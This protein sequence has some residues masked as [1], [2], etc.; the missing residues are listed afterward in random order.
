MSGEYGDSF[1][2]EMPSGKTPLEYAEADDKIQHAGKCNVLN[3]SSHPVTLSLSKSGK[4]FGND[5]KIQPLPAAFRQAQY[6]RKGNDLHNPT[7]PA[8]SREGS[9][10]GKDLLCKAHAHPHTCHPERSPLFGRSR[11]I[12]LA[13]LHNSKYPNYLPVIKLGCLSKQVTFA[14]MDRYRVYPCAFV[15]INFPKY[16]SPLHMDIGKILRS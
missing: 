14:S 11:R 4:R 2:P 8:T 3:Y 10:T 16:F 1:S 12:S 15:Q 7:S 6:D 9:P 5:T 13:R